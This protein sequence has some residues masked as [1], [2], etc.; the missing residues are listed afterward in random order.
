LL[1]DRDHL[2]LS[3][4]RQCALLGFSRS[5]LYYRSV[6]VSDA[7]IW[8][9]R[10]LDEQ[11][12]KTPFYGSRRMAAQ[13]RTQGSQAGRR[14]VASLMR[15]MGLVAIYPKPRLSVPRQ[16]AVHY[17][18]LLRGVS[19][20]RVNQVWSCDITYIRM[21]R[22]FVYLMA[23]MDWHSR[24]VLDWQVSISLDGGFCVETLDRAL[25]RFSVPEIFN[26]DQG[27]QFTSDAF[28]ARLLSADCRVSRDGRG[29]A[30]LAK[31]QV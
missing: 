26:S 31:S 18:Y 9:M 5:A 14:H 4:T 29:R 28:T 23:V 11:Y 6:G 30:A 8:L 19:V 22:G 25:G 20:Q 13:F 15:L 16:D 24:Y 21:A 7:D 27:S 1:I 10:R 2:E 17:P 12:T 3:L